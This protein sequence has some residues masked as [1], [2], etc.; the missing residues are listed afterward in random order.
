MNRGLASNLNGRCWSRSRSVEDGRVSTSQL[1]TGL[2]LVIPG[3]HKKLQMPELLSLPADI[4]TWTVAVLLCASFAS[5]LITVAMGIGGGSLLLAIMASLLPP[6][7]LIPVH[8]VVQLGSNA[9]RLALLFKQ[10][11]WSAIPAFAVGSV[12]G[13]G[14]GGAIVVELP[15]AIVQIGVGAFVIWTVFATAPR[16]LSRWP[17]IAG[18]VSSFLT[19]F[20]GATGPFVASFSKSLNLPRHSHVA[21]HAALMTLQHMLKVLVFG[22]LGFAFG[23]WAAVALTMVMAGFLSTYA[24][25]QVLDRMND[26]FFRRALN[27]VLILVSLR[28]IYAGVSALYR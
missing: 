17:A 7:A 25:R 27:A 4:E 11:H 18:L 23:P 22:L 19:M 2:T 9:G 26:R 8:G 5:S 15:P 20:F 10:V 16:W 1:R 12:A 13:V 24:G 21:T 6:A 14:I 3:P 28:L